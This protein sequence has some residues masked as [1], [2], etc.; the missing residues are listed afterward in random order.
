MPTA[1]PT[2]LS[3]P[4]VRKTMDSVR[5]ASHDDGETNERSSFV[6]SKKIQK[7]S[8]Y[9]VESSV[10]NSTLSCADG[11][12]L[13]DSDNSVSDDYTEDDE[14][15]GRESTPIPFRL[16][17]AIMNPS[18]VLF[19]RHRAS[20]EKDTENEN[21]R[22]ANSR[23]RKTPLKQVS[24]PELSY[25]PESL[26]IEDRKNGNKYLPCTFVVALVLFVIL[27]Y[28]Y[29]LKPPA[30]VPA[31]APAQSVKCEEFYSLEKSYKNID[32]SMWD[33]LLV[34]FARAN[35]REPGTF[36]FLHNGSTRMVDR[37]IEQVT[38]I[39]AD[40]FGGTQPI[41]L[42]SN[43]FK[44]AE[45]EQ[46]FGEIL[47]QQTDALRKQAIMVVRNLEDVPPNAAQAFHSICD[48]EEPLVGKAVIYFTMDTSKITGTVVHSG[49]SATADAEKLLIH[50]WKHVLK[51]E[52]L[53]PLITRLTEQV[54]RIV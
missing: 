15:L 40:C 23:K 51:P 29:Y 17:S 34:T 11:D 31:T 20:V 49:Q 26:P 44:R 30:T 45:I 43:Y 25:E 8:S 10:N 4:T 16:E 54:Y 46:D 41:V 22:P 36:L 19:Q 5:R 28:K 48:P 21:V 18:E 35:R 12:D 52:V 53:D 24:T 37:F 47:S 9:T 2:N 7:Q 38:K 13:I 1:T 32:D 42:G 50:M 14:P 27:Y 6:T 3:G 39:T 33:S